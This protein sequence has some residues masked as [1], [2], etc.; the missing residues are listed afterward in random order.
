MLQTSLK[1]IKQDPDQFGEEILNCFADISEC[2]PKFFKKDFNMLFQMLSA[3]VFDK[4]I[5][6]S[7]LKETATEIMILILE[8]IPSLGKQNKDTLNGILEM[9]FFNMVQIDTEIDQD[10]AN[11]KE[12]FS[13]ENEN[14]EVDS[15]EISFGI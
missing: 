8:R 2:E 10:W 4:N 9:I 12:G 11:P 1:L 7:M 13:D 3:V 6:E 15:D 14:G 5:D